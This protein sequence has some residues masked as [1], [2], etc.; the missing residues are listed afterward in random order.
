MHSRM[1]VSVSQ[2]VTPSGDWMPLK[3][4][5]NTFFAHGQTTTAATTVTTTMPQPWMLAPQN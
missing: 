1:V 4:I 2:G 3:R 5:E